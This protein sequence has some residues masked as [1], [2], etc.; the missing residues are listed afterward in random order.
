M[1]DIKTHE[2][3]ELAHLAR[4]RLPTASGERTAKEVTD[5]LKSF[6]ML[7]DVNTDDVEPSAYPLPIPA[8]LRPDLPDEPLTQDAVLGNAPRK[9]AGCFLVPRVVEG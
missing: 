8:R 7:Q 3:A 2:L 5:L 6:A 1:A 4:L 9:R